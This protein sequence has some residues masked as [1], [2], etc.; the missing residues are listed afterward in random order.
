[1]PRSLAREWARAARDVELQTLQFELEALTAHMDQL[2]KRLDQARA[3]TGAEEGQVWRELRQVIRAKVKVVKAES[4]RLHEA[5]LY[6]TKPEALVL[7]QTVFRALRDAVLN[8]DTFAQGPQAVLLAC[9]RRL[10]AVMGRPEAEDADV[11]DGAV[12]ENQGPEER[13]S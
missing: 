10:S 13:G 6:L 8:A 3:G 1:V 2:L 5:G 12:V 9:Q 7:C 4:R 11:I